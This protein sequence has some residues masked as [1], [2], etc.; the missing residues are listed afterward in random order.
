VGLVAYLT[1]GYPDLGATPELVKAL[2]EGGADLIELGV[3]FSDPLADGATIQRA[4]LRA[5]QNGVTLEG[6][7]AVARRLRR[8]GLEV[9]LILMGYYNP[10]Y[11]YGLERL[12]GQALDAGVDGLIVPDLPPE[13]AGELRGHC[14]ARGLDLIFMLAPA[15]TEERIARVCQMA[16]GFVYC[17]SLTGVTGARSHLSANLASFLARVRGHTGLPLA[18]GFG[19]STPTQVRQVAQM[20]E[21]VVVGSR[22]LELIEE[23]APAERGRAL[24]ALARR[25]KGPL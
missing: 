17:V 18:V 22:L 9:P 8:D 14:T 7:L 20:A 4:S 1:V 25:L 5:L 12:A 3:P 19:I 10:F 23:A 11:R 21:A 2:V 15:S 13:E 24:A 16:S 6:C